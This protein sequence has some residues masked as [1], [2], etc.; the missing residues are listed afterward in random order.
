MSI[1][2]QKTDHK[3]RCLKKL[4]SDILSGQYI[5][6]YVEMITKIQACLYWS[7]H[8]TQYQAYGQMPLKLIRVPKWSVSFIPAIVNS[9]IDHQ[10]H[11]NDAFKEE[12]TQNPELFQK[13]C[14]SNT[15]NLLKVFFEYSD[16]KNNSVSKAMWQ[17]FK[18]HLSIFQLN[19]NHMTKDLYRDQ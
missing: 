9:Q 17:F 10:A 16:N 3:T 15:K 6:E 12:C 19:N 7:Q 1:D 13:Y 14:T 5:F 8:I 2:K 4:R 11:I 18:N